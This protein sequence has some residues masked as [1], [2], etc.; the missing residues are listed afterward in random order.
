VHST[1]L[2]TL[3][4]AAKYAWS[5]S[6]RFETSTV[7]VGFFEGYFGAASFCGFGYL[8]FYSFG[9]AYSF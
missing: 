9:S 5:S 7:G 4:S 6:L 3:K 1:I 8:A 2:P